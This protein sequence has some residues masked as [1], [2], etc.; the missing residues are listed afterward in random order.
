[1]VKSGLPAIVID[2]LFQEN[3]INDE[4][5]RTLQK[6]KEDPQQRCR[7]LLALLHTSGNRQAFVQLYLAIKHVSA[8]EWL[9]EEIDK[10]TDESLVDL[11]Q[12]KLHVSEP[13]GTPNV[14]FNEV[15][16]PCTNTSMT[17][18]GMDFDP[19]TQYTH[20]PAARADIIP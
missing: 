16:F 10:F 2:F 20:F 17:S 18:F 19:L 4:E 6:F 1:M 5:L 8:L 7:E 15:T 14:C 11:V 3:V 13:T 9:I 12:K